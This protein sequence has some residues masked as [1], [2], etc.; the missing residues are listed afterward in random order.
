[1]AVLQGSVQVTHDGVDTLVQAGGQMAT[2]GNQSAS[3]V[4][5]QIAWSHDRDKYLTLLAQL[6]GTQKQVNQIPFASSGTT[7]EKANT[8]NSSK[9][10]HSGKKLLE[11]S[12][13]GEKPYLIAER[14][15][16]N[17]L[18]ENHLNLPLAGTS[19]QGSAPMAS[20]DSIMPKAAKAASVGEVTV[21]QLEEALAAA[22][23]EP[24]ADVAKQLSGLKLIERMNSAKLA[25][26]KADL[27]GDKAREQLV[28]LAD[29]AAFLAP[30]AAEILAD[31]APDSETARKMLA[32]I[33]NYVNTTNR[34][35]PDLLVERDT[36][37]FEDRPQEDVLGRNGI[38]SMAAMPLH[39][40]G[41]SS[42]KVT[43]RD[44]KEVLDGK[45]VKAGNQIG[46][47]ATSGA[48][49]PILGV[50]VG[51]ALHGQITWS[52]WEQGASVKE[53]VF[54]YEVPREK[55]HY[56]V[57]YCCQFDGVRSDNS[58]AMSLFKETVGYHGEIVFDPA[59]GVIL[60]ITLESELPPAELV[61]RASLMVEYSPVEIGGQSYICPVRSVSNLTAFAG[62]LTGAYSMSR[63]RGPSK[64]YLND[65]SFSQYRRIG[66]EPRIKSGRIASQKQ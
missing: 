31:P 6:S 63:Y 2:N 27:P 1:V 55:S 52:R 9:A 7:S 25:E 5:E 60:R 4:A 20:Q 28:I 12:G 8:S 18:P 41:K 66:A 61:S 33:V 45:V 23:G 13:K 11:N 49:G 38:E 29:S 46:G 53:A 3:P 40:T 34:Q 59:S 17:S 36:T 10:D 32:S 50:A 43:Y 15:E 26:L 14:N 48:F 19:Q 47:L 35:L 44:R 39:W 24:D 37:G 51:D 22:H 30:P 56:P 65:V 21:A 57:L 54:H 42:V 62:Q 16:P 58:H 64:T